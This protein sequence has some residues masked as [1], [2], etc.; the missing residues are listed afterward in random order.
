MAQFIPVTLAG[1]IACAF[2]PSAG[3]N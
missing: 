3:E 2:F 1:G